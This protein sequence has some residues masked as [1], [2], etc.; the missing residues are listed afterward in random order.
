MIL[1]YAHSYADNPMSEAC[2]TSTLLSRNKA[3]L[4]IAHG[5]LYACDQNAACKLIFHEVQS[6]AGNDLRSKVGNLTELLIQ[7]RD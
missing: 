2:R 6:E 4:Q 5:I 1:Q 7:Q 3:S